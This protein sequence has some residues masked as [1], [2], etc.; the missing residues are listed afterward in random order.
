M[1]FSEKDIANL[2]SQTGL[3]PKALHRISGTCKVVL[4][5]DDPEGEPKRLEIGLNLERVVSAVVSSALAASL[6]LPL[7]REY[8][9]SCPA[10]ILWLGRGDYD[11]KAIP[12]EISR[13][14]IVHACRTAGRLRAAFLRS[15]ETK[16]KGVK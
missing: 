13:G 8:K 15:V 10:V 3:S 5:A 7:L 1:H 4:Q 11:P 14:M 12:G 6:L 2:S 9:Q 16:V